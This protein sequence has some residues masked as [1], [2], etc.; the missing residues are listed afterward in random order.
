MRKEIIIVILIGIGIGAI[1][2]FGIYTA[3]SAIQTNKSS[4]TEEKTQQATES[5]Q[6]Q[7]I[8]EII[9]PENNSVIDTPTTNLIGRTTPN[10]VVAVIAVENEYLFT[11]DS[12][13][14]FSLEVDLVGGANELL[15]SA[16]DSE[17]NK[18]ED[19]RTVVYST[20]EL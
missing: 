11:A 14:N 2:A 5:P 10:V 4:R 9:E 13:G 20:V 8:L 1:I 6:P 19:A 7:I 18:A 12:Q 15:I 17:G 16:F 3:R